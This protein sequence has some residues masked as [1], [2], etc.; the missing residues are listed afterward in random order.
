MRIGLAD[1]LCLIFEFGAYFVA[2]TFEYFQDQG[3]F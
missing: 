2:S 3:L 1:N